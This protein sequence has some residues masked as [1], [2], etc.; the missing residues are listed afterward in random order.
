VTDQ[1]GAVVPNAKVTVTSPSTGVSQSTQ[2]TS[3][4]TYIF[5]NLLVGTY[6]VDVEA[7]NFKKYTRKEVTVQSNQVSEAHARLEV[8][9]EGTTVEVAAG[10][11]LVQTTSSQLSSTFEARAVTDLPISSLGGSPL[12]LGMLLPNTTTL[13]GGVT[14]DGGSVGGLRPHANSFSIDGADNNNVNLTGKLNDPIPD[15]VGELNIIT[16]QYSAEYGFAGGGQFNIVSKS[17][18]NNVHGETHWFNRNRD[19]NA[20]DNT[21]HAAGLTRAPRNDW[22]RL[23]GSIGGPSSGTNYSSSALMN[24]PRRVWMFNRSPIWRLRLPALLS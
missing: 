1:T 23:G 3:S 12:E 2:T 22:N 19:F 17:G 14:G 9:G 8:G 15:A 6:T 7:P 4:G 24:T 10:S 16:N 20:M 13:I 21:Q 11:E 18:T 5:P